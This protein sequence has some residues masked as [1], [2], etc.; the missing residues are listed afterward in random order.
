MRTHLGQH[1]RR[2]VLFCAIGIAA[3]VIAFQFLYSTDKLLPFT[4]VDGVV[5]SGWNKADAALRLD[6]LYKYKKIGIYFSDA[7][8]AYKSPSAAD[9]G[10]VTTNKARIQAMDYPWY[11]RI[12]PLSILWANVFQNNPGPTYTRNDT[13]LHKYVT[14][15]FGE[16]C[17][18]K[19]VDAGL[20]VKNASLVVVPSVNGGMCDMKNVIT[21]LS[22]LQPNLKTDTKIIISGK[23]IP[24]T[25]SDAV[26]KSFADNLG[27]KLKHDVVVSAGDTSVTI[28]S[29]K[30]YSWLDISVVDGEFV[31]VLNP[32][33]ATTYL[34]EKVAP[35]VAIA[36]GTSQVSTYD[37]VETS[38]VNG[39]NG[40]TLDVPLTVNQIK[41][42]IDNGT[43]NSSAVTKP[44][45]PKVSYTRSYSPTDTGLAALMQNFATTHSGSFGIALT[46]LSGSYRHASYQGDTKFTTASTYKLF[47]AYSTLLRI[48]SGAWHWSD[49]IEG[50]YDLTTCFDRM[51]RLSD[52]AC[53]SAMLSKIGYQAIT[54]EAHAI[55]AT[56]TSFL[57]RDGNGIISSASDEALLLSALQKGQ[58]L[59]QQTNRDIWIN[60]MKSNVYRQGI[61]KGIPSATVADK[62]GFL[63]ALLHDAAIVYS[64]TGTYVLVIMT[65]NSSWATIADLASQIEALRNQ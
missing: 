7:K 4:S 61:P 2:W 20:N 31:Y 35:K 1:W 41:A 26:A 57:G 5:F 24:A 18:V 9:I 49:Q 19:P 33:R 50:G 43:Y 8:L 13:V 3:A 34:N 48:E 36:S 14:S 38:R 42:A 44:V 55:G 58:I 60:A 16:S 17:E 56:T 47:V 10:L 30:L 53:A 25:I 63:D 39:A 51:I 52:N 64:P 11:L 22:S 37:F 28:T 54:N 23:E 21:L 65:N 46:E 62:V 6:N 15:Q 29:D 59:S 32:D 27:T 45:A 12:V 40:A